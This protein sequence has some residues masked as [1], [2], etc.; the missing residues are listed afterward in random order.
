MKRLRIQMILAATLLGG[1]ISLFTACSEKDN[2]G[3]PTT[4]PSADWEKADQLQVK[5]TA[6]VPTAVMS[7]FDQTSMGAA[8]VRRLSQTT[9]EITP[10]TKMILIK[11]EDILNR[12][13]TEWLQAAKLYLRGGYIA[14]EKPRDAHL[15]NVMEQ[16]ANKMAQAEDELLAEDNGNGITITITPYNGASATSNV[17]SAQVARFKSR[18]ANIQAKAG[19][20]AADD[21]QPVAEMVI[22]ARD[23]YYHGAPFQY[24]TTYS[25][26][27]DENGKRQKGKRETI[28]K[29]Y[30]CYAS[31]LK[32]DGAAEWLNSRQQSLAERRAQ[33]RQMAN[34][35]IGTDAINDLMSAS[36]EYTYEN[37]I[38]A[39]LIWL[40]NNEEPIYVGSSD[41]SSKEKAYKETVRIWAAHNMD[42]N[43]DYYFAQQKIVASIGG[44]DESGEDKSHWTYDPNKTLFAGS[45]T[46][47]WIRQKDMNV[48]GEI[49]GYDGYLNI[50]TYYGAWFEFGDFSMNLTGTGD[51]KVEEAVPTTDNNDAS[52]TV[53]VGEYKEET[54]NIG[55]SV[56]PV[57]TTKEAG[58]RPSVSYSHGYTNGTIYTMGYTSNAKELKVQ[59]NTEGSKVTWNYDNGVDMM[60]GEG[61]DHP[62][63]PDALTGDVDIMNQACWSIA[64]PEG[65]YTLSINR[66]IGMANLAGLDDWLD[67]DEVKYYV[68]ITNQYDDGKDWTQVLIIPNR[69]Q[70]TWRMDVDF[71]EIGQPGHEGQKG[72]LTNYLKEQFPDLYQPTIVLADQTPD[73]EN[74]IKNLVNTSKDMLSDENALQTLKGYA[75]DLGISQFTI[76]WY[77]TEGKHNT[78]DMTVK[79][80]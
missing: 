76:K 28:I 57:I 21:Q 9:T 37:C 55:G 35:A 8:L 45:Y 31:G 72:Q 46:D 75:L 59:K 80:K 32:A 18:I 14:I 52:A 63:A 16:L 38:T 56:T 70:Q 61:N 17:S 41:R 27:K 47:K 7:Q 54:T 60:T 66:S 78:Y 19:H 71:P 43:K 58:V 64:N 53:T 40:F 42:T 33:S 36:E 30:S 15:V 62:L 10:E 20:R 77:C 74:T 79:A 65:N 29:E 4:E 22:F 39:S 11:G 49:E 68:S 5:V 1:A 50:N 26:Y 67:W 48:G 69:S 44:K 24:S 13:F 6:D 23:G 12:P 2:A 3:S 51:V 73:S 25:S 34:R